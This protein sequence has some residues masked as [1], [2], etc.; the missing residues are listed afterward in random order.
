M[1]V[2]TGE[3]IFA[4][5]HNVDLTSLQDEMGDMFGVSLL[6][7]W[8][9]AAGI[10]DHWFDGLK[11]KTKVKKEGEVSPKNTKNKNAKVL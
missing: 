2:I 11:V 7:A 9:R 6:A 5:L 8:L 1:A 3:S 10:T 4:D